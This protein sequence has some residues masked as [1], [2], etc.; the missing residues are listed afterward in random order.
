[1]VICLL[2]FSYLA[3]ALNSEQFEL[4]SFLRRKYYAVLVTFIR[5]R[6]KF[7]LLSTLAPIFRHPKLCR[8]PRAHY[9]GLQP[10]WM[11]QGG[12]KCWRRSTLEIPAR[13]RRLCDNSPE[14]SCH[15]LLYDTHL[16]RV[17]PTESKPSNTDSDHGIKTPRTQRR[18]RLHNSCHIPSGDEAK[19]PYQPTKS[20]H[21]EHQQ[22]ALQPLV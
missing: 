2:F 19:L 21:S 14:P 10:S 15:I 18:A 4:L 13:I 22:S 11:H 8:R 9:S 12:L 3:Y 7:K 20:P 16:H 5:Q 17:S 6:S 1:M